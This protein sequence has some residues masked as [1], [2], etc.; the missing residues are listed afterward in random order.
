MFVEP[1]IVMAEIEQ[2]LERCRRGSRG[3]STAAAGLERE[4]QSVHDAWASASSA[5]EVARRVTVNL[6]AAT[7]RLSKVTSYFAA[8]DEAH[9]TLSRPPEQR[10]TYVHALHACLRAQKYLKSHKSFVSAA[11]EARRVSQLLETAGGHLQEKMR[12]LAAAGEVDR[13]VVGCAKLAGFEK[14]AR[15]GWAEARGEVLEREFNV[16]A[17]EDGAAATC[18]QAHDRPYE[19]G[20]HPA[21]RHYKRA[22]SVLARELEL[23]GRAFEE[24]KN[25]FLHD[26]VIAPTMALLKRAVRNALEHV[27]AAPGETA[28]ANGSVLANAEAARAALDLLREHRRQEWPVASPDL[29]AMG[30]ELLDGAVDALRATLGAAAPQ[31]DGTDVNVHLRLA[32]ATSKDVALT[33]VRLADVIIPVERPPWKTTDALSAAALADLAKEAGHGNEEREV[34]T[35]RRRRPSYLTNRLVRRKSAKEPIGAPPAADVEER[36]DAALFA[37]TLVAHL[38]RTVAATTADLR[39]IDD[40]ESHHKVD[41]EDVVFSGAAAEAAAN[42]RAEYYLASVARRMR[43]DLSNDKHVPEDLDAWLAWID[44]AATNAYVRAWSTAAD[45][46]GPLSDHERKRVLEAD[47]RDV[48]SGRGEGAKVLKR[49]FATLNAFMERLA[50]SQTHWVAADP[51]LATTLRATLATLIVEP[52]ADFYE[53]FSK[54]AFSNKHADVYLRWNPPAVHDAIAHLFRSTL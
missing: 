5:T 6:E 7:A 41:V 8:A 12:E 3:C 19:N 2:A 11:D 20:S 22:R 39:V 1:F 38:L 25:E 52:W 26:A 32:C 30:D 40:R 50:L 13:W 51:E 16:F 33:I 23:N 46:A 27:A 31:Q 42:A 36:G 9:M 54:V 48:A 10:D 47:S 15:K 34:S 45:A 35:P 17:E 43:S 14:L 44:G 18:V 37:R 28:D 4:L 49:R 24:T 21:L 29:E 53:R